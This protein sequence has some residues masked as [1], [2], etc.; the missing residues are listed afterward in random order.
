MINFRYHIV[1]LVAVFMAL[2][3]GIVLGA[4]ILGDRIN[5]GIVTQAAQDRKE[6]QEQRA[7]NQRMADLVQYQNE[8]AE[9]VSEPMSEGSLQGQEVVL[10]AMPTARRA[11]VNSIST[12]VSNAGGTVGSTVD[13][14]NNVFDPNRAKATQQV[15]D[16][17]S[18]M[19]SF[20]QEDTS[21]TKLGKLLG[22]SV[23][24][25]DQKPRDQTAEDIIDALGEGNLATVSADSD[26][27]APIVIVVAGGATDPR[28]A[29]EI[30]AAHVEFDQALKAKPD[31]ASAVVVAG[32]N[33]E[34]VE[35]TDVSS[36]RADVSAT[37]S[38][39]TVDVADLPSGVT[40][41]ILAAHEQVLGRQG[42]YG[43]WPSRDDV[44]PKLPVQ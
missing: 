39:S 36:I 16:E 22:R 13:L 41:V 2:A 32:P 21:A 15:L 40:T 25:T 27:R 38:L 29:P 12:A 31:G 37:E 42:H 44:A 24:S 33:S 8:Y 6:L 19:M 28:P 1:S 3:V 26:M 23:L 11:V 14:K 35:G 18:D 10:V 9:K 5:S 20:T 4:T 30:L 17:F 34:D 7:E 43:A